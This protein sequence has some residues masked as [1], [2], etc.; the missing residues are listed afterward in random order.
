MQMQRLFLSP[1]SG[2]FLL[3]LFLLVAFF[4]SQVSKQNLG[5]IPGKCCAGLRIWQALATALRKNWIASLGEVCTMLFAL[6]FSRPSVLQPHWQCAMLTLQ[7]VPFSEGSEM[8]IR[9]KTSSNPECMGRRLCAYK[10]MTCVSQPAV[11]RKPSVNIVY[12]YLNFVGLH[13]FNPDDRTAHAS[14]P[15][16][17]QGAGRN[18]LV[19][20]ELLACDAWYAV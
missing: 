6:W 17:G 19:S 12:L 7:K 10:W 20:R 8:T 14:T 5:R 11:W 9:E 15:S 13:V 2:G 18:Y 3:L 16:D 1:F 4:S